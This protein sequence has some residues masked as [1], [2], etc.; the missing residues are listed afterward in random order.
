[1]MLL[2]RKF[3]SIAASVA[4]HPI[5]SGIA[6]AQTYPTHPV[7]LVV[8]V[9][10][11][12]TP[13]VIGRLL[14][15]ALLEQFDQSIIIENRPGAGGNLALHAVARA[16]PDGY[17]LLQ[18]ATPHAVNVT[19]YEKADVIVTRDIVPVAS[20]NRDWFVLVVNPSFPAK[21]ISEFI[22]YANSNPGKINIASSRAGDMP[23]L[24]AELLRMMTRIDMVN[25]PYRGSPAA[26]SALIAGD[27]QAMFDAAG[28]AVPLIKSGALRAVGVTATAP[29]R[30]LPDVPPIADVVPGYSVTGWL[31]VGAPRGTPPEIVDRL[32]RK[33][34]A[35]LAKP[36]LKAR[37]AELGSEIFTGSPADF[38]K[39]ITEEAEK[40]AKI[41][42][43]AGIRAN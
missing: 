5:L 35:A 23:H 37:M 42:K 27:V 32:N 29:L 41:V 8:F 20:T 9:P 34:N 26:Q 2:R 17:T 13:D 7:T 28:S 12:G 14:G 18:V 30:V 40:W 1:M 21:T 39:L 24:C 33:I 19:L 6:R 11:G 3:L 22:A 16:R 25:V 15:K 31:G 38:E 43:Y 4:I 10:P 36:A